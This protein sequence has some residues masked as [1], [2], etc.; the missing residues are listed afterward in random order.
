MPPPSSQGYFESSLGGDDLDRFI[1]M[2]ARQHSSSFGA[3]AAAAAVVVGGGGSPCS[4]PGAWAEAGG[5]DAWAR[6]LKH[7]LR[8]R[9][10]PEAPPLAASAGGQG[11]GE[12]M[13][14]GSGSDPSVAVA[15]GGSGGVERDG[16]ADFV[17]PDGSTVALDGGLAEACV[18]LL[19]DPASAPAEV[20]KCVSLC[21]GPPAPLLPC[22]L[23]VGTA[24]Q[25]SRPHMD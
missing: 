25:R 4:G 12:A 13:D 6:R 9:R 8:P 24:H 22:L 19:L 18:G 7:S 15:A 16:R 1:Q 17:L 2:S 14:E 23:A 21:G 11:A 3:V 10:P 5:R 20:R